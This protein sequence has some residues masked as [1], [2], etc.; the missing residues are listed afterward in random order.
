[1]TTLPDED[2][3]VIRESSPII[4]HVI[5]TLAIIFAFGSLFFWSAPDWA[6]KLVLAIWTVVPPIW[7]L[8]EWQVLLKSG[9]GK[10]K[11][12]FERFKHSQELASKV[13]LA[14]AAVLAALY[15]GD[16]FHP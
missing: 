2:S 3:K 14:V 8:V 12:W 6:K 9:A 11:E 13:W 10:D 5:T 4:W 15:F 1:M 7:F 16:K